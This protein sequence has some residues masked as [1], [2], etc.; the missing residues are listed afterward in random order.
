MLNHKPGLDLSFRPQ[1][2][3]GT[4]DHRSVVVSRIKGTSRRA[5]VASYMDGKMPGELL[6]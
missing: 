3:I 1:D 6:S 2:Y 4:L 5:L